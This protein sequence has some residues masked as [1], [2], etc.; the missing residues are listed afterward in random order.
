MIKQI[1]SESHRIQI[2]AILTESDV[3][4]ELM[5]T[6]HVKANYANDLETQWKDAQTQM[7]SMIRAAHTMAVY[8]D[9]AHTTAGGQS[10]AP[11]ALTFWL[12]QLKLK[13][14]EGF[15]IDI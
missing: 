6:W 9:K 1:P 14:A 7:P 2:T 3:D 8:A 4:P 11:G 12:N 10:S 13:A 5:S 15:G